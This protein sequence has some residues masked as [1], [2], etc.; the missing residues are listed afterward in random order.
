[1]LTTEKAID[2]TNKKECKL[3]FQHAEHCPMCKS[4]ISG[5]PLFSV[6][7]SH[8]LEELAAIV[9]FCTGCQSVFIEKCSIY[10][11][12][13]NHYHVEDV[14]SSEPNYFVKES[15]DENI[16]TLS[17]QFT[18]IYNQAKV[19]ESMRLD[20][21]TGIGYRK[22]L[23]FLIKDY[24]IHENP[25]DE[26]V[27]KELPLSKCINKYIDD[28]R[29]KQNAEKSTWIGNDETHY[30][31]KHTN[32]DI[33]DMKDFIRAAVYFIAMVLITEKAETIERA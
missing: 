3:E 14:I 9:Y 13:A 4:H 5:I 16:E 7:Y 33:Q 18:K 26:S 27:I 1:M 32:L 29:I 8:G 15:F 17:P 24:A 6:I 19:A 21:I 12:F 23:E 20:E 22:A 11:E 28:S 30:V 10:H 31:K 2:I 25:N